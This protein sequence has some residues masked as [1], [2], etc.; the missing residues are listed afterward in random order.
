MR[1]HGCEV[2]CDL[3]QATVIYGFETISNAS[4]ARSD[5]ATW[6]ENLKTRFWVEKMLN[7]FLLN[8]HRKCFHSMLA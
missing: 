3:L 7:A 8:K 1:K 6:R 4:I 2:I 5:T